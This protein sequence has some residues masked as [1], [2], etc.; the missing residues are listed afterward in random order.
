MVFKPL[1][2]FSG[3]WELPGR[4]QNLVQRFLIIGIWINFLFLLSSTFYVVFIIDSVGYSQLGV[5]LAVSFLVQAALDYP[6]GVIGDWIGQKWTLF[7]AYSVYGAAYGLLVI[8]N[9]F[10]MLFIVYILRA[11]ASSQESG[12][13][14]SWFDNNYKV[15]VEEVD[16]HRKTYKLLLGRRQMINDLTGG[17]IIVIGGVLA[18]L[19]FREAV[20]VIQAIGMFI[21][22]IFF[23]FL[24]SDFPEVE[25][26]EKSVQNYFKLMAEG[27]RIVFLNKVILLFI[28]GI[29]I[30][31]AWMSIYGEMILFPLY[32][33]YTGSDAGASILRSTIWIVGMPI[34][35]LA[36]SFGTRLD[37]KWYPRLNFAHVISLIG[38]F[39]LLTILFP[40]NIRSQPLK[41]NFEPIA[42]I[43]TFVI[44]SLTWIFS[45]T[46]S[47]LYRRMFLDLIPDQNRNSVYSL[48]PTLALIISAPAV[49]IGG[50]LLDSF[51]LTATLSFLGLLGI[52]ASISFYISIQL[53]PSNALDHGSAL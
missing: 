43:I 23:L 7:V 25:K 53:L 51:G 42:I 44:V 32:F 30:T 11:V 24:I 35:G 36:T 37:I 22:A 5:L 46:A 8:S 1:I 17:I 13:L 4:A 34:T 20:F 49:V 31:A 15:A 50:Q 52:I 3:T 14:L 40:I 18:T 16:S 39:I 10:S 6:S 28:I 29:C 41:G 33:C 12:A 2:R 19:Y 45:F 38:S 21:L 9:S 26:P 48:I 27:L 47:L